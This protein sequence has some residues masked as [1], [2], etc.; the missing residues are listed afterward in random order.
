MGKIKH[1][2][3]L[4]LFMVAMCGCEQSPEPPEYSQLEIAPYTLPMSI[5]LPS[6]EAGVMDVEFECKDG[7][8][9]VVPIHLVTTSLPILRQPAEK[10]WY[11]AQGDL[12]LLPETIYQSA[13]YDSYPNDCDFVYSYKWVTLSTYKYSGS[14]KGV[15][16]ISWEKNST[17]EYRRIFL[18][19]G[20]TE[21]TELELR[22]DK[23]PE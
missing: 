11:Y 3:H 2:L 22:Q 20:Y 5:E 9:P 12:V 6:T 14:N 15:L 1:H 17:D 13:G 21:M 19:L 23:I 8:E 18:L 10:W 4:V 16:R 7:S